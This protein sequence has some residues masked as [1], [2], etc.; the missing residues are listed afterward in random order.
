MNLH[1][2][3]SQFIKFG[4]VGVLAFFIDYGIMVALVTL[5][6]MNAVV[7]SAI[8]FSISVVFN[9]YASMRY[10][11]THREGMSRKKEFVIFVL[12]SIIGLAINTALMYVGVE[13][14]Y[15]SYLLVK[16]FATAVVLLWNF[17]SRKIWL[18]AP[19]AGY[20]LPER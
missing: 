16:L 7:A 5:C 4:L 2:L 9:Y 14:M 6:H 13:L 8:S 18:D 15:I 3:I 20:E 19:D 1:K 12:L 11:F 10:V 17:I